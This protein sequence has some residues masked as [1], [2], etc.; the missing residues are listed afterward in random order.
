MPLMH[1]NV[2]TGSDA[3]RA[4]AERMKALVAELAEKSAAVERGGPEDV[5]RKDG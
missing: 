3:F 4:N 2:A 5:A 1:S